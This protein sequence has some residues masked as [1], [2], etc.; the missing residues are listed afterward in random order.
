MLVLCNSF[1]N[2]ASCVISLR[3]V[4]Q[5]KY[6]PIC[7]KPFITLH[8]KVNNIA[9]ADTIVRAAVLDILS[10]PSDQLDLRMHKPS[11]YYSFL[12]DFFFPFLICFITLY[13]LISL[14][15]AFSFF[16]VTPA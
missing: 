14:H 16:Y 15:S 3:K 5:Y 13:L 7:H 10:A 11:F 12:K 8:M 9:T 1:I 6:I 4:S 2:V